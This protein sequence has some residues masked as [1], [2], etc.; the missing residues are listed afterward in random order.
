MLRELPLNQVKMT[1]KFWDN[2]VKLIKNATIPFQYKVLNDDVDD[3]EYLRDR[4]SYAL[5]NLRIAAGLSQGEHHGMSFQD[6][7]VYKWLDAVG[8]SLQVKPDKELQET[9]DK[10]VDLIAAAQQA[11]GYIDTSFCI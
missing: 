8:C 1:G 6:S 7:D 11:D 4:K 10:V 9:A 2:Y 3:I 5:E